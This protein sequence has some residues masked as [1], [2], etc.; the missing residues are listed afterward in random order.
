MFLIQLVLVILVGLNAG[1]YCWVNPITTR[2]YIKDRF[3]ETA[4]SK[5]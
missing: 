1:F 3:I 4:T 2:D 5:V